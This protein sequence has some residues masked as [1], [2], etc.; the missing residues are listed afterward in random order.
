V[1]VSFGSDWAAMTQ[2]D[3]PR[4][5]GS[6]IGF[7]DGI[8]LSKH[9]FHG[10]PVGCTRPDIGEAHAPFFVENEGRW[11]GQIAANAEPVH[12]FQVFVQDEWKRK[13]ARRGIGLR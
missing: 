8:E 6:E 12:N 9:R 2:K 7:P 1:R 10:W 3:L 11:L 5:P 4:P 13:L